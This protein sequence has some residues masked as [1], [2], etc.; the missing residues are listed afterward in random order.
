MIIIFL[1]Y[2]NELFCDRY[3]YKYDNFYILM[4]IVTQ[5]GFLECKKCTSC[6]SCLKARREML[7]PDGNGVCRAPSVCSRAVGYV[8]AQVQGSLGH[9]I[10][11][12][13]SNLNFKRRRLVIYC[14]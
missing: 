1:V 13:E 6:R 4:V 12:R 11:I 10:N 14:N 9:L 7:Y 2:G 5:L 8:E 3:I